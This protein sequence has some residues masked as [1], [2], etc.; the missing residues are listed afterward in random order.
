M[1]WA[2]IVKR[3][4][5]K[6]REY[7]SKTRDTDEEEGQIFVPPS[8]EPSSRWKRDPNTKLQPNGEVTDI[9]MEET[10]AF[11]THDTHTASSDNTAS[12]DKWLARDIVIYQTKFEPGAFDSTF[13]YPMGK[14]LND[15]FVRS[16]LEYTHSMRATMVFE[17]V[18]GE[19]KVQAAGVMVTYM[20]FFGDNMEYGFLSESGDDLTSDIRQKL[21]R[22]TLLSNPEHVIVSPQH[23]TRVT[24]RIPFFWQREYMSLVAR[25]GMSL[26]RLYISHLVPVRE[27]GE[28]TGIPALPFT[29]LMHLEDVEV[30]GATATPLPAMPIV[31][32][33]ALELNE[34]FNT[35]SQLPLIYGGESIQSV[36]Q[37]TK[38]STL[39]FTTNRSDQQGTTHIQF[40]ALPPYPGF[41]VDKGS[42]S[43]ASRDYNSVNMTPFTYFRSMFAGIRGSMKYI[44]FQHSACTSC[45]S[46]LYRTTLTD[47]FIGIHKST[48]SNTADTMIHALE[49]NLDHFTGSEISTSHNP[50]VHI[51]VPHQTNNLFQRS[52]T[53]GNPE[54][55]LNVLLRIYNNDGPSQEMVYFTPGEDTQMV[56]Y[57]GPPLMHIGHWIV[58]HNRRR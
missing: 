35:S 12:L 10:E 26:G 39:L 17:I 52:R 33:N 13:V 32:Q 31:I 43:F 20:P 40:P 38:R 57:V 7:F 11:I 6:L 2:D 19:S 58:D 44:I 56:G 37:L 49:D 15:G 28:K 30:K 54:T 4:Q 50:V 25:E 45:P 48:D 41:S 23:T 55:Y 9:P 34:A 36:K 18:I 42:H 53:T 47:D 16:K 22:L 29:I 5:S 8:Y 14:F 21:S 27:V 3:I 1:D 51:E 46:A 24:F